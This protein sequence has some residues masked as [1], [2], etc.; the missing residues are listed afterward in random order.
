[1]I[2]YQLL[3]IQNPWWGSKELIVNDPKLKEFQQAAIKHYPHQVLDLLLEPSA[4][5]I[6]SGPRQT[7]KSTA[8]KLL[9]QQLIEK[10]PAETIF[11]FNCD[12]LANK[13]ELIN[14]V[15]S[16]FD[17]LKNR[18]GESTNNYIFLDEISSVPDWSYGVK[19]LA[20][21][22]LLRRSK[23]ILTGSSSINLKKSGEFLPGRRQG[24]QD[25]AFLPIDFFTYLKLLITRINIE[26]A[27]SFEELRR[28]AQQLQTT[29]ISIQK[30]YNDF[31]LTGGFLKVI[32][33]FWKK[34]SLSEVVEIYQSTIKSELAKFG[35]KEIHA[36]AILNKIV[37]SLTAETSYVNIAEESELGS[38][39]TA[40]DY[41]NFF[42]DAFLLKEVF[43]YEIAQKRVVIKKNKK[44]YPTDPFILWMF[45]VLISAS[46]QIELF[47]QKYMTTPLD[48]QLAELFVASELYKKRLDFYFFKN[49][50]ELD[51]YLPT[52]EI[53]IEVKYKDRIIRDDMVGLR[54]AKRKLLVSKNLLLQKENVLVVPA[55]LFGLINWADFDF[56]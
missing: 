10:Q 20:D 24:G 41:L 26:P 21:S 3:V 44:F 2:D 40:S 52:R 49:Q 7:G 33:R 36:R 31:L 51:F 18:Y 12:A 17:Q 43:F 47:Y 8:L 1:M 4:I 34:E 56:R 6:V 9:I 16:F 55:Y 35:K 5:N 28:L 14:L 25:I 46:N 29:G 38:K 45:Q 30:F 32:D 53:G 19:W 50:S 15:L 11:Y 23:I 27:S 39:N 22:G 48:S 37:R 42:A 13:Q 54:P